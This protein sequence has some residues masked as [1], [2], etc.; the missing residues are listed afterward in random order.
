MKYS[1]NPF[2]WMLWLGRWAKDR[3]IETDLHLRG[4]EVRKRVRQ[5]RHAGISPDDHVLWVGGRLA[6]I[7]WVCIEYREEAEHALQSDPTRKQDHK[8]MGF[9]VNFDDNIEIE[10]RQK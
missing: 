1:V 8:F 10:F 6:D 5:I 9:E 7:T 4:Y 3:K 2:K